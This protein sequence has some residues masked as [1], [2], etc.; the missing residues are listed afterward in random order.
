MESKDHLRRRRI[1]A[2]KNARLDSARRA[3]KPRAEGRA[4]AGRR[5]GS[6]HEYGV[7]EFVNDQRFLLQQGDENPQLAGRVDG[8]RQPYLRVPTGKILS[9]LE[10]PSA[11]RMFLRR[12]EARGWDLFLRF[13]G[14]IRFIQ[15]RKDE[16]ARCGLGVSE[17]RRALVSEEFIAFLL[18]RPMLRAAEPHGFLPLTTY[19]ARRQHTSTS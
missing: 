14:A 16:I 2:L 5:V 15:E 3:Q 10:R 13:A 7:R 18:S 11:A 4:G 12:Y 17:S 1:R 19:I 6:R 8:T 9:A